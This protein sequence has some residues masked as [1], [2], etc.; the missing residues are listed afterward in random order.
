ME[1]R[2]RVVTT[3]SNIFC[4]AKLDWQ[5]IGNI[6]LRGVTPSFRVPCNQQKSPLSP[7]LSITPSPI[8]AALHTLDASLLDRW[9]V[10]YPNRG[11]NDSIP[12]AAVNA[13]HWHC[14]LDRCNCCS[15]SH[16]HHLRSFRRGLEWPPDDIRILFAESAAA[17]LSIR[18]DDFSENSP[19]V[20][21]FLF[22]CFFFSFSRIWRECN[23]FMY[24]GRV[25]GRERN[26]NY[27]LVYKE[28][29]GIGGIYFSK[30]NLE[31]R[32]LEG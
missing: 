23:C 21:T 8:L 2:S 4:V 13:P 6:R 27:Y 9:N 11:D 18:F 28:F 25:R 26:W 22:E 10:W 30:S 14:S 29:I 5:F 20:Y 19:G 32:K 16:L 7:S 1:S 3:N 15:R 17:S 31:W 24:T 12:L